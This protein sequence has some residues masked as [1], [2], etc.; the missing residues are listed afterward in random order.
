MSSASR[1]RADDLRQIE[2]GRL[3]ALDL[4]AKRV[5]VAVTDELQI[6][7]TPLAPLERRNWKHFLQRVVNIIESYDARAL[8]I[9]LPLN[10][11]GT[12][13]PAAADAV[14]IAENF[15]KSLRVPVF[16][17]D[18]RLTSIAAETELRARGADS[19]EI[20]RRID[21]ASAAIIL[22]DYLAR[23]DQ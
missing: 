1:D 7:V 2:S 21:S 16:L 3:L 23:G 8:I 18:E 11:D 15:R 17:Q 12:K 14:R 19:K 10:M 20:E 5:G 4:G 22:R 13:G 6:T 9:G